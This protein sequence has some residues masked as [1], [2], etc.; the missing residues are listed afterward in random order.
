V[1]GS[2]KELLENEVKPLITTFLTERG[3]ELS[4]EKTHI[5]HI[6]DGFDFLGQNVRKYHGKLLITPS[7]K[8]IAAFLTKVRGLITTHRQTPAGE[9]IQVLNPVSAAGRTTTAMWSAS[10]PTATSTARSCRPSGAGPN[11]AT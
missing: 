7:K 6:D 5:T 2:S 4:A 8:N 10:E 11:G 3:L 9:L 1:T